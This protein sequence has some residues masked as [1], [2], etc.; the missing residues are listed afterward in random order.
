M[1]LAPNTDPVPASVNRYLLSDERNII[2]VH[3][4]PSVLMPPWA[5]AIGGVFAATAASA[6]PGD[7]GTPELVVLT[8]MAFLILKAILNTVRYFFQYLVVTQRRFIQ[9]TG[10]FV[11]KVKDMP[12]TNLDEMT[13][14]RS[15]AGRILGYGTIRIGPES[16]GQ[17]IIDYVPY[18]DQFYLE[19]KAVL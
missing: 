9:V 14:E 8:L 2:S 7:T 11:R 5:A 12:L 13:F 4:H 6:F 15:L 18:P 16:D 1:R 10:L 19:V 17:Q 3:Q